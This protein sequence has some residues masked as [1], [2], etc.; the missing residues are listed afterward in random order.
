[1][2]SCRFRERG[3]VPSIKA[4]WQTGIAVLVVIQLAGDFV[5]PLG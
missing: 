2:E 1:M 3:L 4:A 5:G